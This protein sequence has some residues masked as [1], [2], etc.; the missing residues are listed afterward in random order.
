[1]PPVIDDHDLDKDLSVK[2]NKSLVI[3]C[4]VTGIPS[5]SVMWLKDKAPLLD[6][7][8]RNLKVTNDDRRLEISDAQVEDAGRYTCRA[9]NPA[10]QDE[11]SFQVKVQGMNFTIYLKSEWNVSLY[12]H[13]IKINYRGTSFNKILKLNSWPIWWDLIFWQF[14]IKNLF[15][16]CLFSITVPPAIDGSHHTWDLSVIER[17]PINL[18]CHA[19]GIPEPLITWLKDQEIIVMSENTHLRMLAG[20]QVLQIASSKV[21]DAARYTCHAENAAGI[22]KKFFNLEVHGKFSL[23]SVFL[24]TTVW[25]KPYCRWQPPQSHYTVTRLNSLCAILQDQC[26]WVL[27]LTT[28][29]D[30]ERSTKY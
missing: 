29:K 7:P 10:G 5:P 21:T 24:F 12:S 23:Y 27:I 9:T 26:L 4:P 16:L 11:V 17:A 30:V 28:F 20:G 3:T 14:G 18:D 22:S 25:I 13:K 19:I 6:F 2:E 15:K 1:M 8:Y